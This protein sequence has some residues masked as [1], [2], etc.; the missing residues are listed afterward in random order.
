M[1]S[2]SM[3]SI[4]ILFQALRWWHYSNVKLAALTEGEKKLTDILKEKLNPTFV[5][6]RDIS[7]E[8]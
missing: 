1:A 3:Y 5:E 4:I 2:Q 8:D 6:V 7:G